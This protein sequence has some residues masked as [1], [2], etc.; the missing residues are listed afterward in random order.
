MSYSI[1]DR[2]V[3]RLTAS[4]WNR[5]A[6][7]VLLEARRGHHGPPLT[8]E[9]LYPLLAQFDPTQRPAW[10]RIIPGMA[11]LRTPGAQGEEVGR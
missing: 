4:R 1:F 8:D 3:Y 6:S 5:L 11:G 2:L 7:A 10:R 9:Q